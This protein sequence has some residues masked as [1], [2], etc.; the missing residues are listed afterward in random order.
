MCNYYGIDQTR[1]YENS[2]KDFALMTNFYQ[3]DLTTLEYSQIPDDFFDVVL[4]SHVIEHLPNG[5]RV[6]EQLIHKLKVGGNIYIEFPGARSIE[7]PR[8]KGTLN[9]YDDDTHCRIYSI[10]EL[11][12]ILSR[13]DCVVLRSGIRRDWFRVI[14]TPVKIVYS[15]IK[16]GYVDGSVFWDVLGFAEYIFAEKQ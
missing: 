6:L 4:M 1:E 8:M 12:A 7:L 14:L 2:R 10:S 16:L 3:I 13:N 5:D 11:S 9:F 15:K